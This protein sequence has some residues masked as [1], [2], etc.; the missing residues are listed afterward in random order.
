M[1]MKMGIISKTKKELLEGVNLKAKC[2][3]A[4]LDSVQ[5]F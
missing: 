3:Q 2:T 4:Y 1:R 5:A